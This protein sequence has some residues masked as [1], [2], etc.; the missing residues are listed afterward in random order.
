[1]RPFQALVAIFFVSGTL[2]RSIGLGYHTPGDRVEGTPT[3]KIEVI[4]EIDTYV[5]LPQS[6]RYNREEAVLMLTDIYGLP[7]V[8]NKLLV[9]LIPFAF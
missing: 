2:A 3:G 1:M 8:N 6:G 9:R 4:N 5:S 7:L